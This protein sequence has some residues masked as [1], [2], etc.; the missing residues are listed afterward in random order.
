MTNGFFVCKARK[1][2][3]EKIPGLTSAG[4]PRLFFVCLV[5]FVVQIL[6]QIGLRA[7]PALGC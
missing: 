1:T 6:L 3:E 5:Y 7:M 2:L 4:S